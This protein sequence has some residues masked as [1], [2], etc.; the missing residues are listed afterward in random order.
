VAGLVNAHDPGIVTLAGLAPV[1]R[2]AAP[3]AFADA[4]HGGLMAFHRADPPR[5]AEAVHGV[6]GPVRGALAV[7]FDEITSPASLAC[8]AD[9]PR[10]ELEALPVSG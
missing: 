3:E 4:F 10:S 8:W 7:A 1:V 5:L 2:R 9:G 6:D